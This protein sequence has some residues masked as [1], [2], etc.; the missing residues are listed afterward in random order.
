MTGEGTGGRRLRDIHTEAGSE[1]KAS[2][3]F[4]FPDTLA[5][6]ERNLGERSHSLPV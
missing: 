6:D 4:P 3:P 1:R 2:P 5:D